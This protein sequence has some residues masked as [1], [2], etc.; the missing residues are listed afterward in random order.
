MCAAWPSRIS[1]CI[2]AHVSDSNA[3]YWRSQRHVLV[4]ADSKKTG[5]MA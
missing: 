5:A 2:K 3:V 4:T 1:V